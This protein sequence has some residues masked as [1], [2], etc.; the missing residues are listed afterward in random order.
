M[1]GEV[2]NMRRRLRGAL[3]RNRCV[4]TS[5]AAYRHR[6]C[7]PQD[8]VI[9]SYPKSGNTWLKFLLTDLLLGADANFDL[10]ERAIPLVGARECGAASLPGGGRLWKSHEPYSSVYGRRC[11]RAVYLV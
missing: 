11:R 3:R 10:A 4:R 8:V 6:V 1:T 5:A 9:A 7:S 2:P